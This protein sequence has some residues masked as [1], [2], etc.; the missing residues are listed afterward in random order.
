MPSLSALGG[1]GTGTVPPPW[2]CTAQPS[3]GGRGRDTRLI[4]AQEAPL[5]LNLAGS[6]G[7]G[8]GSAT[9]RDARSP[10][11]PMGPSAAAHP[12]WGPVLGA[13][14]RQAEAPHSQSTG[15]AGFADSAAV[16]PAFRW[17]TGTEERGK[18][19]HWQPGDCQGEFAELLSPNTRA[20]RGTHPARPLPCLPP[21]AEPLPGVGDT[22]GTSLAEGMAKHWVKPWDR[23]AQPSACLSFPLHPR[24]LGGGCGGDSHA[25]RSCS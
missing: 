9:V 21:A 10:P 20:A 3:W 4:Q 25:S 22:V 8:A 13:A 5:K 24:G 12:E 19:Q 11:A 16:G 6:Q 23:Q 15:A 1:D 17:E 18:K 2:P 14:R 7:H